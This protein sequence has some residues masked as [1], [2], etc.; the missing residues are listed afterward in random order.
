MVARFLRATPDAHAEKPQIIF[1][2]VVPK[3]DAREALV[4]ARECDVELGPVLS[5]KRSGLWYRYSLV[6]LDKTQESRRVCLQVVDLLLLSD[7]L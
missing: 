4:V 7:L 5:T 6:R 2:G 1:V 3:L